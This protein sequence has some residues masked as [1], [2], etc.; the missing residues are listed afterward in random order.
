MLNYEN[1]EA[2]EHIQARFRGVDITSMGD[3]SILIGEIEKKHQKAIE[4]FGKTPSPEKNKIFKHFDS[5]L[6]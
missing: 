3:M 2:L 5:S 1:L 6:S 4:E